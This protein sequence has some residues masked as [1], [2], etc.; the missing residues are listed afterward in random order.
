MKIVVHQADSEN[1]WLLLS[2]RFMTKFGLVF[3]LTPKSAFS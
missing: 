1:E 3:V 2:A